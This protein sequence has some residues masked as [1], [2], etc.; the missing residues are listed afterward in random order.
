M[1]VEWTLMMLN[2]FSILTQYEKI[3]SYKKQTIIEKLVFVVGQGHQRLE[4]LNQ[5]LYQITKLTAIQ[6][7]KVSRKRYDDVRIALGKRKSG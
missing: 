2:L 4:L 7:L 5:T 3:L 1:T 6:N